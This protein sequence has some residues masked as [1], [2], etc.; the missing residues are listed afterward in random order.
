[1]PDSQMIQNGAG[2]AEIAAIG[3]IAKRLIRRDRVETLILQGIG[4][5][6]GHKAYPA[7]FLLFVDQESAAFFRDG[8]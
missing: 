1:M 7:P 6:F 5:Q 8:S 3:F 2:Q 4:S